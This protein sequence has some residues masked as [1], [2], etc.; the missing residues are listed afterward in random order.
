MIRKT[1]FAAALALITS[2]SALPL[3]AQGHDE[4]AARAE[5]NEQR[6]AAMGEAFALAGIWLEAQREY[7]AIPA[8]SVAVVKGQDT[9]WAEGFGYTDRAQTKP[10]TPDTIYSI[11]SISKLFTSVA[12]MQQW[13]RGEVRL[14][15]PVTSYLPWA[16]LQPDE[17]DS[18]PVT[19]RGLLT[20]SAGLPRESRHGY[21]SGS[22][23]FPTQA[24]IRAEIGAQSPLFPASRE[25][26]YSNLGLTL[27]GETVEAVSGEPYADY[28]TS[29]IITPLGLE[30]TQPVMQADKYGQQMAVGWGS[31]GR[32]GTRPEIAIFDARGI[33]PAAGY[34]STVNDLA[35]FAKWQLRLLKDETPELLRASTLREMQRVQYIAPDWDNS[36]GLG[37]A[38]W[39]QDGRNVAGHGG[40]CPGYR[41]SFMID[42]GGDMAITVMMNTMDSPGALARG[43]GALM[44]KR[45]GTSDLSG[46]E[47]VPDLAEF[48]GHY[49]SQPWANE[50]VIMPWAGGLVT[51]DLPTGDPANDIGLMKPLGGDRFV[52]LNDKGRERDVIEFIRDEGG[53][54]TALR[55]FENTYPLVRPIE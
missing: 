25:W 42:P 44:Q 4:R 48:A 5:A 39:N 10:A 50:F 12:L 27:V 13:E 31:R 32:D 53:N 30:N 6:T 15:E 11:C 43:I 20:H 8:L 9:V 37:F 19:M 2:L 26:Q 54:V 21:W 16:T 24:E 52:A 35:N 22:H 51:L 28:V 49:D 1:A 46:A 45:V 29:N 23:T 3:S 14:D 18:V 41:S 36:W 55:R 33:A 40:S 7:N 47:K 38:V 17:R 34:S